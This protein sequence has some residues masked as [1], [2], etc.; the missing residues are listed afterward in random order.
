MIPRKLGLLP[1]AVF[2]FLATQA[3]A[4]P[5]ATLPGI[6]SVTFWEESSLPSCSPC[7][8]TFA[9]GGTELATRLADPLTGSN[10]DFQGTGGEYYDV[11]YSDSDG[12]QNASGAFIS[13]E[14]IFA[15]ANDSA[16]N[17]SAVSLNFDDATK[18][19]ASSIASTLVFDLINPGAAVPAS[20][21]NAL[22]NNLGTFTLMGNT[23]GV[24]GRMRLT[25]GFESSAVI[26]I[27]AALPLFGTGLG[28]VGLMGWRRKRTAGADA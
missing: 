23:A 2:V 12:T 14:A 15:N 11:F 16:L 1:A 6:S 24:D 21:V 26:P 20:Y 10:L 17:I 9:S 25:L 7:A 13:I 5:I 27:P 8:F 22:G 18:E 19:Y 28:V 3:H 4:A